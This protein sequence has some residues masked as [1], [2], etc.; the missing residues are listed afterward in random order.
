MA[1]FIT[2]GVGFNSIE[3]DAII[4][5]GWEKT[6][7]AEAKRANPGLVG[8]PVDEFGRVIA[9]EKPATKAAPTK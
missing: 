5:A 6:T 3:D 1:L 2:N 7:E 9:E 4:P 8:I